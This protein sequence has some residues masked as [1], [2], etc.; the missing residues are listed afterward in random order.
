MGRVDGEGAGDDPGNGDRIEPVDHPAGLED[1]E[2]AALPGEGR[3]NAGHGLDLPPDRRFDLL[4]DPG[5]LA[6]EA[7]GKNGERGVRLGEGGFLV[8]PPY[9]G[10]IAF[11]V[12]EI[13]ESGP[14]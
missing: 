7:A 1:G 13:G 6:R 10:E 11:E 3:R 12:A 2:V 9:G 4:G 8:L 5:K 14:H